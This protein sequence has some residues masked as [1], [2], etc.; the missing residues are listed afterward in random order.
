MKENNIHWCVCGDS[1]YAT[2]KSKCVNAYEG[3]H[4]DKVTWYFTAY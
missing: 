3:S 4:L 2:W 1:F